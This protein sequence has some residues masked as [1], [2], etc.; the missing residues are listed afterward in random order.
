MAHHLAVL[1][2]LMQQPYNIS[3]LHVRRALSPLKPLP[4]LQVFIS[5]IQPYFIAGMVPLMV[6]YF[7]IQVIIVLFFSPACHTNAVSDSPSR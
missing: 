2:L 7:I 3:N 5:I 4:T 1:Q 6:V